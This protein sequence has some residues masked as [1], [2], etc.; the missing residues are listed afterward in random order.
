MSES[1]KHQKSSSQLA[2]LWEKGINGILADE[3][4]LGKT[5]QTL[6]VFCNQQDRL[7]LRKKLEE[8]PTRTDNL[9][10]DSRA[11]RDES[12]DCRDSRG[13]S[14]KANA[15]EFFPTF[16]RQFGL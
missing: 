10:L 9:Y 15:I 7:A 5:I 14:S 11:S 13:E 4:G 2:K 8:V 16:V 6:A 1:V 3:M 12:R